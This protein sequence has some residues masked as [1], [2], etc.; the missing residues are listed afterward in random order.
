MTIEYLLTKC[1]SDNYLFHE[2][3]VSKY[4]FEKY[5]F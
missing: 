4:L 5:L 1:P 3:L 2:N